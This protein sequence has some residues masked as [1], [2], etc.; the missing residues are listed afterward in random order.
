MN[1]ALRVFARSIRRFPWLKKLL[2]RCFVCTARFFYGTPERRMHS[3]FMVKAVLDDAQTC[4][5]YF[6][7]CPENENGDILFHKV[8]NKTSLALRREHSVKIK[9]Q[10]A[11]LEVACITTNAFNWQQGSRAQWVSSSTFIYNKVKDGKVVAEIVNVDDLSSHEFTEPV[12]DAT[13]KYFL[14]IGY[15]R[16]TA[17]GSEYGYPQLEVN[18]TQF[19]SVGRGEGIR[20]VDMASGIVRQIASLAAIS[21]LGERKI[22]ETQWQVINHLKIN[23]ESSCAVFLHRYKEAGAQK[24]R[25][26]CLDMATETLSLVYESDLIS[27]YCWID[28]FR[29]LAYA[30]GPA[31]RYGYYSIHI[32][33]GSLIY[34]SALE[35]FGD[36][37]P[38]FSKGVLAFDTYPDTRGMQQLY[39]IR[40]LFDQDA[41][42]ELI[43]E[44]YHPL[45]FDGATRCD[46]H[47]RLNRTATKLYVDTVQSGTRQ[48]LEIDLSKGGENSCSKLL[49]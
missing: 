44:F 4:F 41:T 15:D 36:G 40:N 16:L 5:G 38:T 20:K 42:A 37:H 43:G 10:R 47:P 45:N 22:S 14:S 32:D 24:D 13:T 18:Y 26:V 21:R 17:L 28:E 11:G 9:V 48:L 1:D 34:V 29:L 23:E 3:K 49:R 27:H 31:G 8:P 12:Q 6:D 25:L 46:L 30:C 19:K 33:T 35:G 2:K 7:C 39:L